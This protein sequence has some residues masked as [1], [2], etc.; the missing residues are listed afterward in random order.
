MER[1]KT[2]ILDALTKKGSAL[3][4]IYLMDQSTNTAN[5]EYLEYIQDIWKHLLK[6]IDPN[7]LKVNIM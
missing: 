5:E 7:D 4:R 1:Q 3:C 6:F 2:T